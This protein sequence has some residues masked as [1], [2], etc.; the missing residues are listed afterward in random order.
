MFKILLDYYI[1]VFE[2]VDGGA[3]YSPYLGSLPSTSLDITERVD[4]KGLDK[5]SE[6]MENN[7]FG[8]DASDVTL[9]IH[10]FDDLFTPG[11]FKIDT[12][13]F[14]E[15]YDYYTS[16]HTPH[17]AID[18]VSG[19]LVKVFWEDSEVFRGVAVGLNNAKFDGTYPK[20]VDVHFYSYIDVIRNA[21]AV[22]DEDGNVSDGSYNAPMSLAQ[23]QDEVGLLV[24]YNGGYV[25]WRSRETI[26]LSFD[27]SGIAEFDYTIK[28]SD[29]KFY[30]IWQNPIDKRVFA[31]Y[32]GDGVTVNVGEV[33]AN[34]L[35]LMFSFDYYSG[36][37]RFIRFIRANVCSETFGIIRRNSER[38][39]EMWTFDYDG[40]E[41]Y[42]DRITNWNMIGATP[43]YYETYV[44]QYYVGYANVSGDL[45]PVVFYFAASDTY[46]S[47]IESDG[48]SLYRCYD[49]GDNKIDKY[50]IPL[51]GVSIATFVSS[52]ILNSPRPVD[53]T[54]I[55]ITGT[56]I[57]TY[58]ANYGGRIFLYKILY[59]AA[60]AIQAKESVLSSLFPLAGAVYRV[61]PTYYG[62]FDDSGR[63][64]MYKTD[65]TSNEISETFSVNDPLFVALSSMF[66][67]S[68][69]IEDILS[70]IAQFFNAVLFT[71]ENIIYLVQKDT[72]MDS[73]TIS[74]SWMGDKTYSK[75]IIDD[76]KTTPKISLK[77]KGALDSNDKY[78]TNTVVGNLRV[79]YRDQLQDIF[80]VVTCVIPTVKALE[81]KIGDEIT[82]HETGE[83]GVLIKRDMGFS[84]NGRM[85][86]LEFKGGI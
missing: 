14:I 39:K 21:T 31:L 54:H 45:T 40:T 82:I 85:T 56:D 12:T 29:T 47:R 53:W 67:D 49:D 50:S 65:V 60:G 59:G 34:S 73:H 33:R 76:R 52:Y 13:D 86:E 83:S 36:A 27:M 46:N 6:Q 17:P 55:Y 58:R 75:S 62:T 28:F 81:Y 2:V 32:A 5:Y 25:D 43:L 80:R 7:R 74:T 11:T 63:G 41:Y 16:A 84:P 79:F 3:V 38:H 20:M 69:T 35:E 77:A 37:T 23:F 9:K 78:D 1:S 64:E 57:I 72:Y 48:H 22:M 44:Y 71:R 10:N 18:Y 66:Y 61:Y 68:P 26:D 42:N 19:W 24:D 51:S 4:I 70:D 30:D 15:V 8:W